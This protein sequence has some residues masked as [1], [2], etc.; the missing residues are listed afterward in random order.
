MRRHA[1]RWRR[2]NSRP[3]AVVVGIR[4]PVEAAEVFAAQVAVVAAFAAPVAE[5][6]SQRA[7]LHYHRLLP[8]SSSC[9]DGKRWALGMEACDFRQHWQYNVYRRERR[10]FHLDCLCVCGHARRF[11]PAGNWVTRTPPATAIRTTGLPRTHLLVTT[12]DLDPAAT[13]A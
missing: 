2:R 1:C 10:R 7:Q 11:L 8:A 12:I 6:G 13:S 9:R 5:A 3:L 4:V